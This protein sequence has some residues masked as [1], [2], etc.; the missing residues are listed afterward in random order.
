MDAGRAV[1]LVIVA[2]IVVLVSL[3][4]GGLGQDDPDPTA[5]PSAVT[6]GA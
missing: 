2:V 4:L 1:R 3:W 5:R 6:S